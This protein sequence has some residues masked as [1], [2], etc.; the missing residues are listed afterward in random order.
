MEH[1][2]TPPNMLFVLAYSAGMFGGVCQESTKFN[3]W[4]GARYYEIIVDGIPEVSLTEQV[5]FIL[6]YVQEKRWRMGSAGT[7]SEND[8][9]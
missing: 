4:V 8:G 7:I 9:L 6:K 2:V 3:S 5:I 1:C